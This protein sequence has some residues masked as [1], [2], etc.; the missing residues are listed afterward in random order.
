MRQACLWRRRTSRTAPPDEDKDVTTYR[1]NAVTLF[2]RRD[3][4]HGQGRGSAVGRAAQNAATQ[5]MP[6]TIKAAPIN[7]PAPAG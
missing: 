6:A 1:R 5:M 7:R 3:E 4:R 2:L